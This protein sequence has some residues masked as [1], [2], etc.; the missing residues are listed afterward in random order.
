MLFR[1][2]E[3]NIIL[4]ENGRWHWMEDKYLSGLC[5]KGVNYI[6]DNR[7]GLV[8]FNNPKPTL[9]KRIKNFFKR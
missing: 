3:S 8:D 1:I 6:L 7:T 2:E 5:I 4:V 9:K